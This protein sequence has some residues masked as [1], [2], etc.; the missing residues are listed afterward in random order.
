MSRSA[1]IERRAL[2]LVEQLLDL[3]LN[4]VARADLLA[5]ESEAVR[6][7]VK[8]LKA[9][10][11]DSAALLPTEFP[12]G[13]DTDES[14]PAPERVGAFRLVRRIGAG[15]MGGVWLA[16]RDD[17]LYEQ[18]VAVK[19]IRPGLVNLAGAAFRAE[20]QILARL[21][22]PNI[23][24]LIDGG[25]TSD[26]V[27]YL[28]MEYVDGL[29][30]D[31]AVMDR[32]LPERIKLFIKAADAVQFAHSRL[33][34]HADLKPSNI[35]VDSNGRVKLLDF[36]IA[37][38]MEGEGDEAGAPLPMTRAYASPQRVKGMAPTTADDVYALGK[39]LAE[40]TSAESDAD[41]K[42]IAA[43]ATHAEETQRYGSVAALIADLDRWRDQLPITARSS[44]V[45][46]RARLFV[47]R[48]LL[49]VFLTGTA[50]AVLTAISAIA[51]HNAIR[52]EQNRARA[53]QRFDE[54]RQLS[55]F[56]LYDL[57]DA[58]ARQPGT[59]EKRAQIASTS[60]DYLARLNLSAESSPSLRLDAA[61]SY[62]RL[63]AIQGLSGTSNLGRPADALRSLDRADEILQDGGGDAP[64][65]RAD[66]LSERGWARLD[67][68][69]LQPDNA[70]SHRENEEA[71]RL[72]DEAA[73]I[74][75]DR[76][77]I[78]LGLLVTE[79]NAAYDAIWSQ[80]D[81]RRAELLA[82]KAL[83]Q[84]R[85]RSWPDALSETAAK[86]AIELL[87]NLGEA[88]YQLDQLPAALQAYREVGQII[89]RLIA[90]QGP[91][92]NL[93][94]LKGQ[95][96]F[97][98]SGTLGDMPG[99]EQEALGIA[100]EGEALLKR[101]L[102]QGP[103]AAAEKKL[104]VLYGQEA[105]LLG[106]L[107]RPNDAVTPSAA[108]VALREARLRGSP[109]DPQRMRDLVIGL[110]SHA[111]RLAEAGQG[112]KACEAARRT[113]ALWQQ[114]EAR[115]RLGALDARKNVP[116]AHERQEKYCSR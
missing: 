25:V 78:A 5:G 98:L 30:I 48:H 20:R 46:Y 70:A 54:V 74:T 52:A 99:H 55:K 47:R 2:A 116:K 69:L 10:M 9:V 24:R 49:G 67:R 61:R 103:D 59:V 50:L 60:A 19:L 88:H 84:L 65:L 107:G 6:A 72:F 94:I 36:G 113:V 38:L 42:A 28:V 96:S 81:A 45:R 111:D 56:M 91:M 101:M 23:A 17:G 112:G 32:P 33:V 93:L 63:A 85:G 100:R 82:D 14:A 29:P 1:E 68:W 108:S 86:L 66:F 95:N 92:P 73:K 11:T 51:I 106:A 41:L 15:G 31:E 76:P 8:A 89:D 77:D 71:R 79:K 105:L 26:G 115:K 83:A 18:R 35:F 21:E 109:D 53:E 40:L 27:P 87:S 75:P 110:G 43:M 58:L 97:D 22:H 39:I 90:S 13:L 114:I 37:R 7:R 57:Y 16:E 34:V 62:R 104:L 44:T 80:D 102:A 3:P 12:D 64:D 4:E